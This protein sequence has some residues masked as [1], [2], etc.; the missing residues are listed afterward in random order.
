MIRAWKGLE[1]FDGRAS[2]RTWLYKIATNVCLDA[3]TDESRRFRPIEDGPP[4]GPNAP[5]NQRP[6]KHW[7]EPIPDAKVIP[8]HADP[9]QVVAMRQS[10]RLAF[11]AALQHLP[12]KQRAVLL[13]VEVVGWSPA[14]VAE[15][16]DLSIAAVNSALQRSRATL[17]TRKIS[18]P[19]PLTESQSKLLES[20]VDAFHRYD[21]DRLA[22]L[23]KEDATMSMPPFDLWLQGPDQVR[24]W[25]LGRGSV[26]RGSRLIPTAACGAPAF[27]HYHPTPDGSGFVPWGIIVL[28]MDGDRIAG[29]NSFLDT[30]TL[31]PIFGLPQK[32]DD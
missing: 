11:V 16:L 15:G 1:R 28:E 22:S 9:L 13:L 12:P 25:L 32:L 21:V 4:P 3:L 31:F 17:A 20:Y 30:E 26:C 24:A 2:L 10:I 19:G 5:L 14:E 18:D 27:G 8:D 6:R 7:L 29:W 23:L